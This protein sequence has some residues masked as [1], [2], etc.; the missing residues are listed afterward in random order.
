MPRYRVQVERRIVTV[1]RT[2]ITVD[3]PDAVGALTT[4]AY[5]ARGVLSG[6]A[7][8][9]GPRIEAVSATKIVNRP[10]IE[11]VRLEIDNAR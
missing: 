2:I 4:A 9:D 1:E 11:P 8:V 3:A 5:A 6:W 10:A 7:A